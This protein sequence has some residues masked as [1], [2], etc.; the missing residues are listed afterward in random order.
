MNG[1]TGVILGTS[2]SQF[3]FP[4][5][6]MQF[7]YKHA[8]LRFT[9]LDGSLSVQDATTRYAESHTISAN[10][11]RWDQYKA[12]FEKSLAA[13]L[14]SIRQGAPP[15]V[16]GMAGLEELQFEA[17]VRRSISQK[18]PVDVQQEFSLES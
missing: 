1:A 12:S 5:Y 10:H 9:D 6:D 15:P 16:P 2:G 14:D 13:Y 3:S 17:A 4:L 7:N 18:R 8:S 11:S